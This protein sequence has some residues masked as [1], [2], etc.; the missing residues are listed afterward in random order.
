MDSDCSRHPRPALSEQS[1]QITLQ[2]VLINKPKFFKVTRDLYRKDEIYEIPRP[3]V[4]GCLVLWVPW[5]L[6]LTVLRYILG[7]AEF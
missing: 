7:G 4:E 2:S 5:F 6:S 3:M 1:R